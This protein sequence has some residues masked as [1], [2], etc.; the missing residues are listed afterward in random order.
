MSTASTQTGAPSFRPV[1]GLG[2]LTFFGVAFVGPTAPYAMFGIGSAN[3]RGHFA[4]V[5]VL[6][7]VAMVF[8]AISYGRMV[9]AHPNAGSAYA[10]AS[11]EV[12]PTAGYFAGW[13]MML[14]YVLMPIISVV[15]ISS[16]VG[17]L[18]PEIPYPVW[19][20]GWAAL[21]TVINLLGI[22]VTARFTV[23]WTLVLAASVLWF[24]GAAVAALLS[25]TGAGTLLSVKPFYDPASFDLGAMRSAF[26]IAVLSYLGFDG[27]ST[28]AEDT[29]NAPRDVPRATIATCLICGATFTGLTYLGALVWGD[30]RTIPAAETA[31]S[32]VG[33]IMG[34]TALFTAIAAL[35]VGQAFTSAVTSQASASRLLF[36][37]ARERRLPRMIFGYIHPRLNTPVY[38]VMLLGGLSALGPLVMN[39]DQAA[40][41]VSFGACL[42][43]IFVNLSA[44]LRAGREW[45]RHT[46]GLAALLAPAA[47]LLVCVYIWLGLS[48]AAMKL[49]FGWCL[50]GLVYFAFLN[51]KGPVNP[52]PAERRRDIHE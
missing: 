18:L 50:A 16:T 34:G 11:A 31:F 6:A 4:L 25:G 2:A 19:V 5:Y 23:I 38:S 27:I 29:R 32:E 47:G 3:S 22:E 42:G 14:D 40:Q 15:I 7:A 52:A 39:L 12:H 30:W 51:H 8:T 1:L 28:L 46:G 10:Y 13:A 36:G 33:R 9:R 24:V 20:I 37:M 44:L 21:I 48:S 45:Q 35:V 43:F 41:F 26:A 17:R 49:G